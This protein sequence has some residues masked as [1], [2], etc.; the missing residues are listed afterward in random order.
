[1]GVDSLAIVGE[2]KRTVTSWLHAQASRLM[3]LS[4]L[5]VTQLSF[6]L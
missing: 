6:S 1:M 2:R 3:S 4:R 5:G